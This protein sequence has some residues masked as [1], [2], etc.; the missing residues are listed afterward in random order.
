MLALREAGMRRL[1]AACWAERCAPRLLGTCE[2]LGSGAA[3][4]ALLSL[5][6]A[7][8]EALLAGGLGTGALSA[9]EVR[10]AEDNESDCDG[11]D[12]GGNSGG[13]DGDDDS[14]DDPAPPTLVRCDSASRRSQLRAAVALTAGCGCDGGEPPRDTV[15][16]SALVL[17]CWL[18]TAGAGGGGGGVAS[19]LRCEHAP[20]GAAP[21]GARLALHELAV[22]VLPRTSLWSAVACDGGAAAVLGASTGV[23]RYDVTSGGPPAALCRALGSDALAVACPADGSA[24][25]ALAGLRNGRVIRADSRAPGGGGC[26]FALRGALT[27]LSLIGA[28]GR[29][30]LA[31]CIDGTLGEWDVRGGRG[32]GPVG[33]L[34]RYAGHRNTQSPLLRRPREEKSSYGI[35]VT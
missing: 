30:V 27:S 10:W 29:R 6:L 22:H 12:A 20:W 4:G 16:D 28:D 5:R 33:C 31:A 9:L 11:G 2:R 8:G 15:P 3:D 25:A 24:A 26:C 19:V 17:A 7:G 14:P 13:G 34:R 18:S 35:N 1:D 21:R 32:G 23:Y